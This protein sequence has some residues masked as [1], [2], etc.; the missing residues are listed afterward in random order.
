MASRPLASILRWTAIP[1]AAV[2]AVALVGIGPRPAL[3][4]VPTTTDPAQAAAGWLARQLINGEHFG[5]TF[6]GVEYP[7][8]G[9][10]ID[11]LFALAA[12]GV[13]GTN[14]E[15][16]I[17]WLATPAVLNGYLGTA[18]DPYYP[19]FAA[20]ATAKTIL[21]AQIAGK[22]P[23][24]FGGIDLVTRLVSLQKPSGRFSDTFA[25]DY[26]N[27][28]GQSFAVVALNRTGGHPTETANGT[29]FLAGTQCADGGFPLYFAGPTCDSQVDAT[30]YVVQ[31]LLA[32]GDSATATKGLTWLI[33]KQKAD[34]G[35]TDGN[36]AKESPE[37]ANSTGLAAQALHLGGKTTAANS[38]VAFLKTLQVG[39][40][41][42][43][44]NQ[45]GIA[46]TAA[47]FDTSTAPRS[48]AQAILGL[49]GAGLGSLSTEGA[50]ADAPTLECA[51]PTT[52]ASTPTAG[53]TTT[54]HPTTTAPASGTTTTASTTTT[55]TTGA[56]GVTTTTRL[57]GALPV[58]GT[59]LPPILFAGAGLVVVGAVLLV[60]LWLHRRA[61]EA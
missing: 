28:F 48:T 45:G 61:T 41:G 1:L 55:T 8:Q 5:A 16:I 13:A 58:T 9:L 21:A 4:A 14:T 39:C 33:G 47:G 24:A 54:S 3:A 44:V 31:A 60:G 34:G 30:A 27:A 22:N 15:K 20:G 19:G 11:A 38:A 17:T 2:A 56:V 26:S 6:Q 29:A 51:V 52:P 43:A 40:G 10:T 59:S 57:A 37:N 53:P 46:Y 12:A 25:T 18:D 23:A 35:F 36:A 49:T 50:Q 7:D 32:A 42:A